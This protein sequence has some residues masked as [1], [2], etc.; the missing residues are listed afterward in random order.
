MPFADFAV[1][2]PAYAIMPYR[3]SRQLIPAT[4][5]SSPITARMK[6]VWASGR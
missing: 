4:P 5:S 6:S 2:R 3:K 1:R